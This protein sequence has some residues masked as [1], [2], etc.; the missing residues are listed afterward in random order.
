MLS[1]PAFT[2]TTVRPHTFTAHAVPF[3]Y[4]FIR[5]KSYVGMESTHEVQIIGGDMS[6][7]KDRNVLLVED[8]ID[9]G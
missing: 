8:I 6:R 2:V 1:S 9:T 4:D 3:T 7:L 5:V